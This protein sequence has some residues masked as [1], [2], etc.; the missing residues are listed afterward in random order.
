MRNTTKIAI[1]VLVIAAIMSAAFLGYNRQVFNEFNLPV[2]P[3]KNPFDWAVDLAMD[4]RISPIPS[5]LVDEYGRGKASKYFGLFSDLISEPNIQSRYDKLREKLL[6]NKYIEDSSNAFILEKSALEMVAGELT[7]Y[8][9]DDNPSKSSAELRTKDEVTYY[10]KANRYLATKAGDYVLS[11]LDTYRGNHPAFWETPLILLF[12][13]KNQGLGL[14]IEGKTAIDSPEPVIMEAALQLAA[15]VYYDENHTANIEKITQELS[16]KKIGRYYLTTGES[17]IREECIRRG[18]LFYEQEQESNKV[19]SNIIKETLECAFEVAKNSAY[20]CNNNFDELLCGD[21][22]FR[23]RFFNILTENKLS[24]PLNEMRHEY[25]G[26]GV[27]S[28]VTDSIKDQNIITAGYKRYLKVIPKIAV[29]NFEYAFFMLY[30]LDDK[31]LTGGYYAEPI[32]NYGDKEKTT[33]RWLSSYDKESKKFVCDS[34][35]FQCGEKKKQW[36]IAKSDLT[37]CK[38]S[39]GPAEK[40][41]SFVG[42]TDRPTT[43]DYSDSNG[44]IYKVDVINDASYWTYYTSKEACVSEQINATKSL[45]DKYR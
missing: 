24:I 15:T 40:L 19:I 14:I 22:V 30:G 8:P 39:G 27:A 32:S 42:Y 31:S 9:E 18:E 13:P 25:R 17:S 2:A 1:I 10:L 4:Y 33:W 37:E 7:T 44:N 12:N 34:F 16:L 6:E 5:G 36:W 3:E 45:A 11:A 29:K 35:E 43:K 20:R 28:M 26:A 23:G 21:S 38:I 41:D